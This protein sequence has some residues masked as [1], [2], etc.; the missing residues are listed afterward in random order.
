[1]LDK[2]AQ[3]HTFIKEVI[4]SEN[5]NGNTLGNA[6]GDLVGKIVVGGVVVLILFVVGFFMNLGKP[7]TDDTSKT[8]NVEK[9]VVETPKSTGAITENEA[10][11][12]CQDA[13]LIGRYLN[14]SE[15]NIIQL[16]DYGKHYSQ[17]DKGDRH[18]G[19][20]IWNGEE[21]KTDRP[22]RFTCEIHRINDGVID[23]DFFM[24][25][26]TVFVDNISE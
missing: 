19:T 2:A 8:D 18:S 15:I 6:L 20:L 14:L 22:L 24:V 26:N 25:N 11:I 21:E 1:M 4:M 3:L 17:N 23:L 10:E 5:N 16:L 7:K 13:A 9:T 12:Y